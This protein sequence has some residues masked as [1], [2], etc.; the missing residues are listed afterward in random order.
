[1]NGSPFAESLNSAKGLPFSVQ[2]DSGA[3]GRA[4]GMRFPASAEQAAEA[5]E[6]AGNAFHLLL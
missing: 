5:V 3:N 2:K 1:M 6:E 4:G